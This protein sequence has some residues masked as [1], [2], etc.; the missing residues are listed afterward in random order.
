[1]TTT[2]PQSVMSVVMAAPTVETRN[3]SRRRLSLV[4]Q[5][6]MEGEVGHTHREKSATHT[7]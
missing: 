7:G 3:L 1:M 4:E 2:L 6:D 5:K